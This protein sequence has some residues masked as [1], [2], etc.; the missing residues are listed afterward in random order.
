[1]A[2]DPRSPPPP[3]V[4]F[5][6]GAP[7][8][9]TTWLQSLL[10]AHPE[11]VTP[12]ETDLFS[13]LVSPLQSWWDRELARTD[14]QQRARRNKGLPAVLDDQQFNAMLRGCI[15]QVLDAIRALKPGASVIVEKSPSHSRHTDLI[16][17][18]LPDAAFIHLIRDGRDVMA[19]LQAAS[20]GWGSYWA[21]RTLKGAATAWK[22]NVT[23]ARGAA[24][25]GRYLEVR[26]EQ[27]HAGEV[28]PLQQA[29]ALC[30]QTVPADRCRELLADYSLDRMASG[31]AKS[32][33]AVGGAMGG[34]P[35]GGTDGGAT[36]GATNVGAERVEP[37]G[38]FGRGTVG[39]WRNEWSTAD[40]LLVDAVA[41]DLLIEL[42]YE[43]DHRWAG[44]AFQ[45]RKYALEVAAARLVGRVGRRIGKRS[46]RALAKLP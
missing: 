23:A 21:P 13:T 45:H 17:D 28:E 14:D 41:G 7:R 22:T 42:G 16:S 43:P 1:M 33:I 30:G 37:S 18:F 9:G 27:L 34:G 36:G 10:G 4:V 15:D 38:F 25:S 19:S 12:Q 6:V 40:R 39:G 35:G 44:S 11:I 2:L 24:T 26:Y 8:S 31:A 32:P 29:F 46:E 3:T 20:A 5:L